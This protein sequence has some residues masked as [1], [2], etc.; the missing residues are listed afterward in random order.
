MEDLS[1]TAGGTI[2]LLA[3]AGDIIL[4]G[5]SASA[6]T[7][8]HSDTTGHVLLKADSGAILLNSGL[9]GGSGHISLLASTDITLGGVDNTHADIT[10]T[11]TGTLDLEAGGAITIHDG[12]R[13]SAASGNMR[14]QA[15]AAMTLGELHTTGDV[16]LQASSISDSGTMDTDISAKQLL[17]RTTGTAA[18]NGAGVVDNPLE[19]NVTTLA[20]DVAGT[21]G[22]FLIEADDLR[23]DQVGQISVNRVKAEGTVE[24]S[25]VHHAQLV[26]VRS[27]GQVV[28][29]AS[30]GTVDM[31][32]VVSSLGG[33]I[34]ITGD[35]VT[36]AANITTTGAASAT[37]TA[38]TGAITMSDGVISTTDTGAIS[39][40]AA[41]DVS[42]SQLLST[43]G[44]ITVT[45][46]VGSIKDSTSAETAN[47]ITSDTLTLTA[48]T[49]MG[50]SGAD[51]IDTTVGTLTATNS[52][53]GD[54]YVQESQGLVIAGNGC[55]LYTSPSPRDGLLSRM[56]SSA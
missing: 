4:N 35:A 55:L 14:L 16:S 25:V 6:T 33:V 32:V 56:P 44:V 48:A 30:D 26:D 21:G 15:A 49:G 42:L 3:T 7:V 36:Q 34:E 41:T 38:D 2:V 51:D 12:N 31:H 23:L 22:L 17:I 20:A 53:S 13:L 50:A 40:T 24:G 27:A 5:G 19:V 28:L 18:G 11:G 8:I 47:L 9:H 37:I 39:Y 1:T 10:T 46:T 29:R 45:A 52:T 43:S 54:I